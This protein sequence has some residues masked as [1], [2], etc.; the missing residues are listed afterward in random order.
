MRPLGFISNGLTSAL[1]D[2]GSVVWLVFPRFDS[3][4]IFGKLLDDEGGEF[5]IFPEDECDV[6]VSYVNAN[7]LSTKFR[8][9]QGEAEIMDVMPI[10]ERSLVRVVR[11]TIPLKVKV[12]PMFH[13]GLYKP[14][15]E[16]HEEGVRFMNP[17]SREC[18]ALTPN[19][20]VISPPGATLYLIYST[21]RDYGPFK[22][23]IER[24]AEKSLRATLNYWERK[25]PFKGTDET[26]RIRE[27]SLM[28][29]LSSIYSPTGASIAAP[30]TSLPEIEGGGRNWD[31]RYTW[32]RDSSM[33]SEALLSTGYIVESRRIINFLLGSMTFSSKPFLHPLYTVDGGD[34]PP[35]REIKWLSGFKGSKPVRVGNGAA[36]QVQLDIEGFFVEAVYQYYLKTGDAEFLRENW[37]KL[38]YI[39]EWVSKNWKLKDAGIWE[40]RG[41][42]QHYTHS[43]VMMWIAL[44][45]IEKMGK[46]IGKKVSTSSKEKLRQWIIENCVKDSYFVRY[47]GSEEV[48]ANLLTLPIYGFVDVRDPVFMNTLRKVE[49]DLLKN[50]FVKRYRKD[51]MGEAVHPFTLANVWLARIYARLGREEEAIKLI[52]NLTRPSSNLYLIGEHI[53]VDKMEYTGNY[54]QVFTHAQILLAIEEINGKS[55][56]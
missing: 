20:H 17:K 9:G 4:S 30:T 47:A 1:I 18:L 43:K 21:A 37:V 56:I 23:R 32:V 16:E 36:S 45:R 41:R 13:Y 55:K 40:D 44:D 24:K 12:K 25:V 26:D 53:D 8:C 10:G 11:T 6:S 3:P 15:V 51:F 22:K 27:V 46:E 39:H 14:I 52:K 54:P 48:D 33:V 42:P 2:N 7:V 31:Y 19:L 38:E 50:G 28:V 35:E 34:P 29:L 5:S 49:T